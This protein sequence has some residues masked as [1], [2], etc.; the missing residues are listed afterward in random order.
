MR[1]S[2][3]RKLKV[4]SYDADLSMDSLNSVVPL[5]IDRN[6]K[7]NIEI[8]PNNR[9]HKRLLDTNHMNEIEGKPENKQS[10]I[11]CGREILEKLNSLRNVYKKY[12]LFVFLLKKLFNIFEIFKNV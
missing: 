5:R 9:N 12:N 4:D 8:N 6:G 7:I 10:N 11:W 1:N 2:I 3:R